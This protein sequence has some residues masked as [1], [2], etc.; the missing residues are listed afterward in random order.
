MQDSIIFS[1]IHN[2]IYS[3]VSSGIDRKTFLQEVSVMAYFRDNEHFAKI[4]GFSINEKVICM[5]YYRL[6]SLH[7]WIH[8]KEKTQ[9]PPY[10]VDCVQFFSMDIG[11][12]LLAMH[13]AGFIHYDLKPQNVF[14]D[15]RKTGEV[16]EVYAVLADFGGAY[17]VDSPSLLVSAFELVEK[18]EATL[19]YAPP[20]IIRRFVHSCEGPRNWNSDQS[21]AVDVYS[22]GM[23]LFELL[24]REEPFDEVETV[25][26]LMASIDSE[27]IPEINQETMSRI[28]KSK[29]LTEIYEIMRDCT[30]LDPEG[31]PKI[32]EVVNRLSR[33]TS[34]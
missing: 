1:Y 2:I 20:E 32:Q 4:I 10:S 11:R 21:K 6:G 34:A 25:H 16:I 9:I 14:L 12:A 13:E 5:K 26:E 7:R 19:R 23:V 24:A 8:R 33:L 22:Y 27:C 29:V 18:K 30:T 15:T 3:H 31:R 28:Q 17:V